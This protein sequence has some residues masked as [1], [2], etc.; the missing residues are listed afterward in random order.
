MN[1]FTSAVAEVK[2]TTFL[3]GI[4]T[5]RAKNHFKTFMRSEMCDFDYYT[6]VYGGHS[7]QHS[8]GRIYA[9]RT[10]INFFWGEKGFGFS[11]LM[12]FCF[13]SGPTHGRQRVEFEASMDHA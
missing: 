13:P 3:D 7:Q 2:L 8:G 10:L 12:R 4:R 11:D 1:P 9:L 5:E 6:C